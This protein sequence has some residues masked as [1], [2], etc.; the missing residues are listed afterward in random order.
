MDHQKLR[1]GCDS[2]REALFDI[3]FESALPFELVLGRLSDTTG[4]GNFSFNRLPTADIPS[5]MRLIDENLKYAPSIELRSLD[6]PSWMIRLGGNSITC[7]QLQ[8]YPGWDIFEPRTKGIIKLLFSKLEQV[9][10]RR[11]GLRYVNSLSN[12]EHGIDSAKRL[13]VT[14]A[15][16]GQPI[17][18]FNLAYRRQSTDQHVNQVVVSTPEFVTQPDN[19]IFSAYVDID[20]STTPTSVYTNAGDV[21][22]WLDV[23]H[24]QL[25]DEYF[26]IIPQDMI[27][28]LGRTKP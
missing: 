25:K 23:A 18:V 19:S 17:E 28:R 13:N 24:F 2:I 6:H 8:P 4:L 27:D 3:R 15:V 1:L 9:T 5:Q 12:H 20:I 14:T 11:I 21:E 16:A 10:V 22:T 26:R 7:H